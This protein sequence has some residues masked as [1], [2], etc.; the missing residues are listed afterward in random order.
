MNTTSAFNVNYKKAIACI[1]L[2]CQFH[3]MFL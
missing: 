3:K 1:K 2:Q